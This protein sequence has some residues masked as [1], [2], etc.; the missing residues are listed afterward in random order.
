MASASWTCPLGTSCRV[1]AD[2]SASSAALLF[3][4]FP[5]KESRRS[6]KDRAARR[7]AH[8]LRAVRLPVA[9]CIERLIPPE[10]AGAVRRVQQPDLFLRSVRRAKATVGQCSFRLFRHGTRLLHLP[11]K[12]AATIYPDIYSMDS[13]EILPAGDASVVI[14]PRNFVGGKRNG[15]FFLF[16]VVE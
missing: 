14:I 7:L 15:C 5:R 1:F 2:V 4:I 11:R 6:E 13:L 10:N 16:P 12:D 3:C 8:A 9:P